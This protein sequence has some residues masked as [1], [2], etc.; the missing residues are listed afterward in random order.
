M[1]RIVEYSG[2]QNSDLISHWVGP[3]LN[4]IT[5]AVPVDTTLVPPP[6]SPPLGFAIAVTK[7]QVKL[8]P[9]A[10]SHWPT[11]TG[12]A[13]MGKTVAKHWRE[14][15]TAGM[16][17]SDDQ[18]RP[19]CA[20][21][22]VK[23]KEPTLDVCPN[24]FFVT[25]VE[26]LTGLVHLVSTCNTAIKATRHGSGCTLLQDGGYMA[27]RERYRDKYTLPAERWTDD[28]THHNGPWVDINGKP[29]RPGV[30]VQCP[31]GPA[32]VMQLGEKWNATE[33]RDQTETW[34]VVLVQIISPVRPQSEIGKHNPQEV[35]TGAYATWNCELLEHIEVIS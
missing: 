19:I 25:N 21:D 11:T 2:L 12:W 1:E 27:T 32:V 10:Q 7:Q 6:V 34:R 26:W 29:L 30:V 8:H 23:T 33:D 20:G 17:V 18:G 14:P 28:R 13:G 5:P 22:R 15:F 4:I 35:R 31:M 9:R 24:N 3:E 16:A